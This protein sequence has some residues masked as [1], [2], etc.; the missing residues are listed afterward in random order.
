MTPPG[1]PAT[2]CWSLAR[3]RSSSR[4][5]PDRAAR[6]VRELL[7]C[8][9]AMAAKPQRCPLLASSRRWWVSMSGWTAP[10]P[11]HRARPGWPPSS[12]APWPSS[13]ASASTA[14]R[15]WR[16]IPGIGPHMARLTG[17]GWP[18]EPSRPGWGGQLVCGPPCRC[19][20]R[21]TLA[22]ARAAESAPLVVTHGDLVSGNVLVSAQGRAWIVDWDDGGPGSTGGQSC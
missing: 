12:A 13:T 2:L 18:I 4:W 6:Q 15:A 7:S 20:P 1:S 10:R 11:R 8:G 14:A 19:W 17:A 16:W 22:A 5:P 3:S 9:V 21:Q